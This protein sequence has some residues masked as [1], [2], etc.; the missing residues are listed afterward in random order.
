[1]AKAFR[2]VQGHGEP[3]KSFATGAVRSESTGKGRF[4]L[5]PPYALKRLAQHFENGAAKYQ[6]RNWE[7]GLPLSRYVDSALRHFNA[8][9]D[10]DR[11]EDHM[12][13]IMWNTACYLHTEREILEGRLPGDLMGVWP[14]TL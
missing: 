14:A 10:G 12:A 4:D 13:A 6:D 2:A 3:V 5:I 8:F 1:M 9:M 11:T 7:K